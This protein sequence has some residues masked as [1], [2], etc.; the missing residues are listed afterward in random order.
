MPEV[1][2]EIGHSITA[3]PCRSARS[4]APERRLPVD[5]RDAVSPV[6]ASLSPED[7]A[8]PDLRARS[9][10]AVCGT[11]RGAGMDA[12]TGADPA[13]GEAAVA[14]PP[15]RR[16]RDASTPRGGRATAPRAEHLRGGPP[17]RSTGRFLAS[18]SRVG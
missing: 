18:I 5:V 14:P 10:R 17:W 2:Q 13:V 1:I 3:F 12:P 7:D 15:E 11:T 8:D 16:S 9:R 4:R 6:G